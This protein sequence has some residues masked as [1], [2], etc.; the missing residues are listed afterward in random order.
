M[1]FSLMAQAKV[2]HLEKFAVSQPD[3]AFLLGVWNTFLQCQRCWKGVVLEVVR[4]DSAGARE[5]SSASGD[6]FSSFDLIEIHPKQ[7]AIVAPEWVPERIANNY[8]EACDSLRRRSFS[9][10]VMMFRKVLDR[11]TRELFS[12]GDAVSPNL[13][14]RIDQLAKQ[15]RITAAMRDW[16]HVIRLDGN[17][18][19]H[20][21]DP[22][23]A[24]AT[25]I[26]QFT[27]LFLLYCFTLPERVMLYH[28]QAS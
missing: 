20:D 13:S 28:D 6:L 10:A 18:A 27:E 19:A 16:A 3:H 1:T 24:S 26:Q 2:G 14:K 4:K 22:D 17:E 5:P 25:Q 23:M 12:E 8:I 11:A 7:A 21:E 15:N 9:S